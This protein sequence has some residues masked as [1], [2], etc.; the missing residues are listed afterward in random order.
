MTVFLWEDL[1]EQRVVEVHVEVFEDI[2]SA[3]TPVE[4]CDSIVTTGEGDVARKLICVTPGRHTI[5][6]K[7]GFK[8]YRAW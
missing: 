7:G 5:W 3:G 2:S 6:V 1:E 4:Y 8:E